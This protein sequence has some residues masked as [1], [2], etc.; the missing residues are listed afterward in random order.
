M[1][2]LDKYSHNIFVKNIETTAVCQLIVIE[3]LHVLIFVLSLFSNPIKI[4]K[5]FLA[6]EKGF[7]RYKD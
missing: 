4:A 7:R 6:K 1:G 3:K 2:I 5:D